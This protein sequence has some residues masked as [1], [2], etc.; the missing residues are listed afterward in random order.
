MMT[1]DFPRAHVID[2]ELMVGVPHEIRQ[3]LDAV[4][5]CGRLERVVQP[6]FR[7][8]TRRSAGALRECVTA[9]V[10]RSMVGRP[11]R[12]T[13][14][15]SSSAPTAGA[16]GTGWQLL[17]GSA[18]EGWAILVTGLL[19]LALRR[20]KWHCEGEA[21][22]AIKARGQAVNEEYGGGPV[23]S[24][25]AGT[26]AGAAARATAATGHSAAGSSGAGGRGS[27]ARGPRARAAATIGEA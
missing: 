27:G 3:H 16:G 22:K 9:M 18:V 13:A 24:A 7:L 11:A 21:L 8:V 6:A 10:A 1:T 20:T 17:S 15:H 2:Y 4:C 23:R 14:A 12:D 5:M 26:R 19:Q 25:R